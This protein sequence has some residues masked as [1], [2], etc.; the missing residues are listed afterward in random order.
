MSTV[1]ITIGAP[2]DRARKP[3]A[4]VLGRRSAWLGFTF[5]INCQTDDHGFVGVHRDISRSQSRGNRD[6][7]AAFVRIKIDGPNGVVANEVE[8]AGL[9]SRDERPN[10][11]GH[12]LID[13]VR[14]E[15]DRG[16][17]ARRGNHQLIA[18]GRISVLMKI[19][20]LA[21]G[22][23]RKPHDEMACRRIDPIGRRLVL[24]PARSR[25]D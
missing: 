8:I 20:T 21:V 22:L 15:I 7:H 9:T 13:F 25:Y 23:D 4:F 14:L 5:R 3:I 10:L 11:A 18:V 1:N 17:P 12:H 2:D 24:R 16:D 19:E 6:H